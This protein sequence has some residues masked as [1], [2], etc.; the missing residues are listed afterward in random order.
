MSTPITEGK[1]AVVNVGVDTFMASL[2]AGGAPAV[3]LDWRP[4]CDGD[5]VLGWQLAQMTGDESDPQAIGT[6]IDRANDEAVARMLAARPM[7]VDVALHARE[8]WPERSGVDLEFRRP[9][10]ARPPPADRVRGNEVV[11]LSSSP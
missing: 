9:E 2:V 1:L 10:V 6:R 5:P 4:A 8:V 11:S 7:L 3:S